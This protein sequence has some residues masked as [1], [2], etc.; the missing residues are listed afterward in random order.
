M[1][2]AA[3]KQIIEDYVTAVSNA[4]TDLLARTFRDDARMWGWLGPELEAVPISEFFKVVDGS[5][6]DMSWKESFSYTIRNVE[7]N[8]KV[9]YGVLEETGYLGAN[10]VTY[11]TC[12]N[13]GQRWQIASKT[14]TMVE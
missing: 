2:Q 1:A 3:V 13:D 8:G 14:F 9:G 7:A 11:F 12:I 5:K 4:D 6:E 10:F